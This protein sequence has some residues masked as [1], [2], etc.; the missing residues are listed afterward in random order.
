MINNLG[1]MPLSISIFASQFLTMSLR[2]VY[3][4][5]LEHLVSKDGEKSENSMIMSLEFMLKMLRK[6]S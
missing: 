4:Q 1:G 6:Q 2:E 3:D 5:E